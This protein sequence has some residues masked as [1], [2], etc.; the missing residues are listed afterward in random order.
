MTPAQAVLLRAAKDAREYFDR[1][2]TGRAG[3][4]MYDVITIG[5]D[6]TDAIAAVESEIREAREVELAAQFVDRR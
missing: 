5:R 1:R 4:G 3:L 6:L 2:V